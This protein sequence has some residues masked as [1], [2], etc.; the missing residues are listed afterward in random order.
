M[1]SLVAAARRVL[2]VLH[3]RPDG[4]SVG[5][6]LALSRCLRGL[7]KEAVVVRPDPVPD[8]LTFLDPDNECLPPASVTGDFDLALFFDCAD[9]DRIGD[10]RPLLARVPRLVNVDHHLSNRSYGDLNYIDPRAGACAELALQ[11]IDDLGYP[12][13][14]RT[15]TALFTA[16]AT[17][18]G[19]FR[20]GNT[21]VATLAMAA[22]LRSAGADLPLI[23]REVW[24]SRGLGALR[25]IG[26]ALDSLGVD[27][28]A[29]LAWVAVTEEDLAATG[30]SSADTEGLVDYPRSLRGVEVS[31]LFVADQ[32]GF[33]RVSL[34]S[35]SRVDVSALAA[36]FGGG[37][38]ARA[39]GCMLSGSLSTVR[40][41]VLD[42]AR[43]ALAEA[44]EGR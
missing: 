24:A 39:A 3:V 14:P 8:N 42:A 38:H 30:C 7:G 21:T 11:L 6:S 18:T 13:D 34:R 23:G 26:R 31:L 17:D 16:L 41:A 25:L 29:E 35:H 10:A 36:R 32:P 5:C 44:V 27:S 1:V 33:V 20:Y 40:D 19:S 9:L 12:L 15:A 22:R 28:G 43:Q 2:L 4:D 37:G